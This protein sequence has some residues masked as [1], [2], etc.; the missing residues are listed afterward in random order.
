MLPKTT[1]KGSAVMS[2]NSRRP[3]STS[4]KK[5]KVIVKTKIEEDSRDCFGLPITNRDLSRLLKE[6]NSKIAS[7]RNT[8]YSK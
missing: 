7:D 6:R 8:V 5:E 2:P 4:V 3:L 1:N